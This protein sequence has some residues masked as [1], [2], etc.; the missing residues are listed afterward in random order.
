MKAIGKTV[1]IIVLMIAAFLAWQ[2]PFT[3]NVYQSLTLDPKT[4]TRDAG[5]LVPALERVAG[6]E[7]PLPGDGARREDARYA[8]AIAYAEK[9]QS[10]SLLI[11]QR[12]ELRVERYMN[13]ASADTRSES[14]SMAKSVT[15]MVVGHALADGVF[16]SIDDPVG[17]YLDE[18][19]TDPRGAIT[20]RQVLHM[21][22]GLENA[23]G[24]GGLLSERSRYQFGLFPEQV[25]LQ[26]KLKGTPGA[27]FEYQNV[28]TNLMGL[29]LT[30]ALPERYAAYLSRKIWQ[31]LGASDAFVWPN[32]PGGLVKTASSFIATPRDWLRM[33]IMLANDGV[34]EGR[35]ALPEG[36]LAQML[37][38]SPRY[39]NYGY[40]IWLSQPY[41]AKRYYN[42]FEAGPYLPAAE[43]FLATDMFYFDGWGGQRVYVSPSEQL[44]IV[45]TGPERLDWDD[46][47]L[48]N[49]V[50]K[51]L[52]TAP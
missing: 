19:V 33:G 39:A 18:W 1:A 30:R 32:R 28:N 17:K 38:P 8:D 10:Y 51:A 9:M 49:F 13:G 22:T 5:K 26:L 7:R 29:V 50:M 2:W 23:S 45:H 40:Q 11:W 14:A 20:L 42:E 41:T 21:A 36:W 43:P 37:T 15:A 4:R 48:P 3:V 31:P 12:G 24:E 25:L 52:A 35:R 16:S 44:V 34:I 27:A 46:S 47:A 6:A